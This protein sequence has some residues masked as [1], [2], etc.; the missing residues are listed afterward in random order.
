MRFFLPSTS[1]MP[2]ELAEAIG[3]AREVG[4]H[5]LVVEIGGGHGAYWAPGGEVSFDVRRRMSLPSV[6]PVSGTG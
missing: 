5:G 4:L 6:G 2:P 3:E 1:K